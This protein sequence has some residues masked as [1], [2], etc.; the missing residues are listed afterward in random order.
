MKR[1]LSKKDIL[2]YLGIL[3]T[4]LAERGKFG[5]IILCGGAALT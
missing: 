2:K 5:E 1:K 4:K 3:N